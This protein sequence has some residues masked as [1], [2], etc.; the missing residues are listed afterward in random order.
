MIGA[1]SHRLLPDEKIRLVGFSKPC[2]ERLSNSLG[3]A[4]VSSIA[5][6]RGAPGAAALWEFVQKTVEPVDVAW[7][8]SMPLAEY[9]PV[10]IRSTETTIGTKR[11][12]QA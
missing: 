1:A 3:I 11:V 12:R 2:F 8:D 9:R 4:R 7:L 5:I 6:L 10:E